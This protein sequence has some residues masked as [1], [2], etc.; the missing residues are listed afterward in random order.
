ME[1]V[2]PILL[3]FVVPLVLC[4][5]LKT[6]AGIM[7]FAACSGIVLL[8]SLDVTFVATAGAVVPG[9]G[10]AVVRLAVVLAAIGIA[11]LAFK[12][13]VHGA[14]IVMHVLLAFLLGCVLWLE[15]PALSGASWLLDSITTT[16]WKFL[17][18]F[19]SPII[20]TGLAL[21]LVLLLS[22]DH[23]YKKRGK[24]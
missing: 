5:V 10:E 17:D 8:S 12:G 9:E 2:V 16:Q 19:Q 4:I 6:N 15:L 1:L 24:H 22:R 7:F 3:F 18:A 23:K 13:S 11:A 14:R 21:S 20:A